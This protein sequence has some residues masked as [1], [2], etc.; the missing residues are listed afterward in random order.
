V[1]VRVIRTAVLLDGMR[2][3]MVIFLKSV[4]F[5]KTLIDPVLNQMNTVKT[6]ATTK[7]NTEAII[8]AAVTALMLKIF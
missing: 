5:A 3:G 7:K 8:A 4:L 2:L 1:A 6:N